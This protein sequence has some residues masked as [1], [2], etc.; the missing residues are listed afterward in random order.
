[1][2]AEKRKAASQP[3]LPAKTR[4][5][6]VEA[7]CK[8][9]YDEVAEEAVKQLFDDHQ[10]KYYPERLAFLEVF[11]NL[12]LRAH[13]LICAKSMKDTYLKLLKTF[14][15]GKKIMNLQ[16]SW[17]MHVNLYFDH[18]LE[19]TGI[20][21]KE[22]KEMSEIWNTLVQKGNE[23]VISMDDQRIIL[24]TLS[25]IVYD[26]MSLK[27]KE[28]KLSMGLCNTATVATCTNSAIEDEQDHC[29]SVS[30]PIYNESRENVFRYAGFAIFSMI[31]KRREQSKV[32]VDEVKLLEVMQRN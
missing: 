4:K 12:P 24:S 17:F 3:K 29:A 28:S 27:V 11:K 14:C 22:A 18:S 13:L 7:V 23:C 30:Q 32:P 15:K 19:V 6:V 31:S 25:Y 10:F 16:Q 21:T 9:D 8:Q 5:I 26:L 1:M 20:T 2:P